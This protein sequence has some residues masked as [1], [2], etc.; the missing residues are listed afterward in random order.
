M[1]FNVLANVKSLTTRCYAVDLVQ[2][3]VRNPHLQE[4]FKQYVF[5][6]LA[7]CSLFSDN[8]AK[9]RHRRITKYKVDNTGSILMV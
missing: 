9:D 1:V 2:D 4:W 5:A 3:L 6:Y 8:Q 7:Y